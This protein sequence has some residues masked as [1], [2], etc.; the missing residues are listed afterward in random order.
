MLLVVSQEQFY[1]A[2]VHTF[3]TSGVQAGAADRTR[4]TLATQRLSVL[5]SSS[6]TTPAGAWYLTAEECRGREPLSALEYSVR[7]DASAFHELRH[8]SAHDV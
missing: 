7:F 8:L 5:S 4:P 3:P 2:R 1:H 6:M